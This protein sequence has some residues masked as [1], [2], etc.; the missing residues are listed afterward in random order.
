MTKPRLA[1]STDRA[2]AGV[3]AG[4]A[5]F[6]GWYPVSIRTLF[7]LLTLLSA[8]SFV[9]AYVLLWWMMPDAEPDKPSFR[10]DDFRA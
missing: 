6:L 1:R 9:A 10:L 7:V 2:I 5:E 3:C 8:G 4:I